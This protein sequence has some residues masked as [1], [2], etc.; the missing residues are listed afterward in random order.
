MKNY[1]ISIAIGIV[2]GTLDI[3]PMIIKRLDMAFTLSAFSMWVVTGLFI[4][5][6]RFIPVHWLNGIVVSLLIFLP[7]FFMIFKMD[8]NALPQV[9]I[10]TVLL[11]AGIGF[12]NGLLIHNFYRLTFDNLFTPQFL[13]LA[14]FQ[15]FLSL[16]PKRN[17]QL[18]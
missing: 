16:K 2:A 15:E 12:L 5:K 10:T 3:I 14:Q 17:L 9:C 18:L 8:K 13:V 6:A 7:L 11:G 1:L 4:L